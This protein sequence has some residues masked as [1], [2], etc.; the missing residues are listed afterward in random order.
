MKCAEDAKIVDISQKL[1]KSEMPLRP[2]YNPQQRRQTIYKS[3][4]QPQR[5]NQLATKPTQQQTR[6]IKQKEARNQQQ[7]SEE[8]IDPQATCYIGEMVEDWQNVNFFQS[9]NFKT[10][11]VTEINKTNR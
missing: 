3:T 10:E 7:A 11:K 2:S 5:V 8:T 1:Y 4:Q 9:N 6:N